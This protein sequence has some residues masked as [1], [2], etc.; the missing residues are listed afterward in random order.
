LKYLYLL[1]SKDDLLP[2]DEVVFNTE[3]HPL[4]MFDIPAHF[5]KRNWRKEVKEA[6]EVPNKL[7]A[8]A[9]PAAAPAEAAGKPAAA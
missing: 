4:P 7:E 5:K 8:E 2:L 9:A 3:A 6:A 1:F